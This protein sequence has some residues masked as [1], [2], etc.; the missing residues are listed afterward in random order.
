MGTRI[1][2]LPTLPV[3]ITVLSSQ[4]IPGFQIPHLYQLCRSGM[5]STPGEYKSLT[6]TIPNH[7][8][9]AHEPTDNY[10]SASKPPVFWQVQR[11]CI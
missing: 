6:W 10:T 8:F 1:M 9:G 2:L 3:E 5:R 11:Q 4:K 7:V